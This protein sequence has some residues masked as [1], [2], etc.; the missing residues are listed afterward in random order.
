MEALVSD[1]V[2][3][4]QLAAMVAIANERS[5]L[6]QE[7]SLTRSFTI[8][9]TIANNATVIEATTHLEQA[10]MVTNTRGMQ[11]CYESA[12]SAISAT[13]RSCATRRRA[14]PC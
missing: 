5:G 3:G 14:T 1:L 13:I 8:D 2:A 11:E 4:F 9:F 10:I 12:L 6:E 7:P